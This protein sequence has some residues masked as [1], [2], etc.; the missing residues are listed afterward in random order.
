MGC[1]QAVRHG[2]LMPILEGSNPSTPS[3]KK[4]LYEI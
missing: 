3:M 4:D 1:R 2:L